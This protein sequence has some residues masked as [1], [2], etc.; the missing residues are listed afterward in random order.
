MATAAVQVLSP[1][2]YVALYGMITPWNEFAEVHKIFEEK[3]KSFK[4][5][6]IDRESGN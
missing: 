2:I 3:R 1:G 5:T 6:G 4:A